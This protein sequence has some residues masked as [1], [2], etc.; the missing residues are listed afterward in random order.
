MKEVTGC[1]RGIVG[2]GLAIEDARRRRFLPEPGTL[3]RRIGL[4]IPC[5]LLT[6]LFAIC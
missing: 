5:A 6:Q 2:V 1:H 4:A 3:T